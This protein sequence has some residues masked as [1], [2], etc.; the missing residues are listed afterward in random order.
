MLAR[1]AR[2]Q[3]SC[4]WIADAACI[5]KA[6]TSKN[7]RMSRAAS[8]LKVELMVEG[9]GES[10]GASMV[11]RSAPATKVLEAMVRRRVRR[12]EWQRA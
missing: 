5:V 11:D 2:L 12:S 10:W 8:E 3:A 1:G 6:L 7:A 4:C 9:L